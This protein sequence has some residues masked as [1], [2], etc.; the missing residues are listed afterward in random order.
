MECCYLKIVETAVLVSLPLLQKSCCI[1]V[2]EYPDTEIKCSLLLSSRL[3]L[4]VVYFGTGFVTLDYEFQ[5]ERSTCASFNFMM[6]DFMDL[7]NLLKTHVSQST[8]NLLRWLILA[9]V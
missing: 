1:V 7:C 9:E 8:S 6:S 2:K 5:Y 4:Q 3:K